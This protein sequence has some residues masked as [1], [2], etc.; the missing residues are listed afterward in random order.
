M[1][2]QEVVR[3]IVLYAITW[4]QLEDVLCLIVLCSQ[5]NIKEPSSLIKLFLPYSIIWLE[6][7]TYCKSGGGRSW[8][9][10]WA[11]LILSVNHI[12]TNSTRRRIGIKCPYH[13][14]TN[15]GE[16]EVTAEQVTVCWGGRAGW[17][18]I[19]L[20]GRGW[21]KNC[22]QRVAA[23]SLGFFRHPKKRRHSELWKKQS[24]LKN[25]LGQKRTG[26]TPL[27]YKQYYVRRT[28]H[29]MFSLLRCH[30]QKRLKIASSS[31][32]SDCTTYGSRM[33]LSTIDSLFILMLWCGCSVGG[34][35][36]NDRVQA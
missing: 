27:P 17:Q 19:M 21:V 18:L 35:H 9:R 20:F 28:V 34:A 29:V 33:F 31:F 32:K 23:S 22:M 2:T 36:L 25:V 10:I 12:F 1:W 7:D 24:F 5:R 26:I 16:F 15:S 3:L 8:D 13:S 4:F 6:L 30:P 11:I 14:K